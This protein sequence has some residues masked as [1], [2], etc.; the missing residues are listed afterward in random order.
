MDGSPIGAAI[1][2]LD[3]GTRLFVNNEL[4]TMFGAQSKQHMLTTDIVATW[5]DR[6]HLERCIQ[7]FNRRENLVNVEAER[8]RFDGDVWWVLLNTQPVVFEGVEAGIVWHIDITARKMAERLLVDAKGEAEDANHAK[9]DF[10][11]HMSHELRTPLNSILGFSQMLASPSS[12]AFTQARKT[13]YARNIFASGTHL[14]DIIN[15]ILDISKIEAGEFELDESEFEIE[16][17]LTVAQRMLR[18]M[19]DEAE[20]NVV[21]GT[22]DDGLPRLYADK[23]VITQVMVNLMSNAIKFNKPG[24]KVAVNP[25]LEKDGGLSILVED[26]GVG[27]A[28]DEI[29]KAM[30]PF[31]QIRS[32][33]QN[34]HEG[35]GLGLSLSVQLVE[36]HAGKFQLT[37]QPGHGTKVLVHFPAARSMALHTRESSAAPVAGD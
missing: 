31:G 35:T 19:A 9:T 10:L 33:S 24:G 4:V 1:L 25:F 30:T 14:L 32:S 12:E 13:D 37:S 18:T 22:P 17:V 3:K 15:D 27:M 28:E 6:D 20:I 11:A 8:R 7:S 36:L 23:R 2:D 29:P 26:T 5:V 16:E 34:S 21:C